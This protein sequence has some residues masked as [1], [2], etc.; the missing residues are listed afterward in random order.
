MDISN[1]PAEESIHFTDGENGGGWPGPD[2][3]K[4]SKTA[5]GGNG[6]GT[7]R[8]V[9]TL[10]HVISIPLRTFI[11]WP[12][13]ASEDGEVGL[14]RVGEEGR[15]RRGHRHQVDR[16]GRPGGRAVDAGDR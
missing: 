4:A 2:E 13:V 8:F 6:T 10:S 14:E 12:I 7:P 1:E 3:R 11:V 9:R 5:S 16:Q 15:G